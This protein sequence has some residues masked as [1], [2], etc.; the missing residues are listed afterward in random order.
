MGTSN[1]GDVPRLAEWMETQPRIAWVLG[2]HG[3]DSASKVA[4]AC[5][6][7]R[8]RL[9]RYQGVLRVHIDHRPVFG[10]SGEDLFRITTALRTPLCWGEWEP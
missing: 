6:K 4:E 9:A 1:L 5:K 10:L 8:I 2:L 7:L 3:L